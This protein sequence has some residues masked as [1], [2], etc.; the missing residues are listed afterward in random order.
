MKLQLN[1]RDL[2]WLVLVVA[3]AC[4]WRLSY[5]SE[6]EAKL[7][8]ERMQMM[9]DALQERLQEVEAEQEPVIA[10]DYSGYKVEIIIDEP[11]NE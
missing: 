3:M 10:S 9:C 5:L 4:A 11:D 2:F 8:A 7:E 6:R 1:L